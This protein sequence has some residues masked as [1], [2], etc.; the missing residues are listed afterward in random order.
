MVPIEVSFAGKEPR[1][2]HAITTALL[3]EQPPFGKSLQA[4]TLISTTSD[5]ASASQLAARAVGRRASS[6]ETKVTSADQ[7]CAALVQ[8]LKQRG[9][10]DDTLIVWG[11]EFGR[12]VYS[13]GTLT[14]DNY[15]RDHHPRCFAMWI[16]G[17]GIR[18][19]LTYGDYGRLQL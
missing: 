9:M 18:G 17:G 19:G 2:E 10:L 1:A 3:L 4:D 8:D 13:Q 15:G 12:T 16:A 11:G 14:E 5:Q 6:H 7:P